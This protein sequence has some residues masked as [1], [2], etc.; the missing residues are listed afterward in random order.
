M[1]RFALLPFA[2]LIAACQ[3]SAPPATEAKPAAAKPAPIVPTADN[4]FS[5]EIKAEDLAAHLK[6]LSSDEFAGRKPGT[7][8]E[9]LTTSYLVEQFKRMGLKPGNGDSYL[10][11]VPM[12]S[13]TLRDPDSLARYTARC[14]MASGASSRRK[15]REW[16]SAASGIRW[17]W[18]RLG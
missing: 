4:A 12:T 7:D 3:P 2:L 1:R 13:T 6:R 18:L 8:G 17:S 11:S 9:R 5:P 14:V 16:I 15:G 10:Q